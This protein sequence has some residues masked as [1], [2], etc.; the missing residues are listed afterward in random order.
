MKKHKENAD[1]QNRGNKQPAFKKPKNKL[2]GIHCNLM[3]QNTPAIFNYLYTKYYEQLIPILMSDEM[4]I[5]YD[6]SLE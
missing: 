5:F 2:E 4:S 1:S 3:V 6:V